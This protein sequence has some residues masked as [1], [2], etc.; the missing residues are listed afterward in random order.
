MK[1]SQIIP[2]FSLLLMSCGSSSD[3]E[4]NAATENTIVKETTEKVADIVNSKQLFSVKCVKV[5]YTIKSGMET[6]T[7]TLYIDDYGAIAVIDFDTKSKLGPKRQTMIWDGKQTTMVNHENK[8]VS[9]SPFRV[10]ATEPPSIADIDDATR[11][12]IGYT[13][14]AD[15]TIAGKTCEVWFNEKQNFKYCLWNKISLKTVLG[16]MINENAISVEELAEIPESV[17]QIP[18]GYSQ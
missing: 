5:V 13:K 15:E 14:E 4:N 16:K 2:A 8:T 3:S 9:T 6:G 12:S 1:F 17:M 18:A 11:K 10:K 7:Q